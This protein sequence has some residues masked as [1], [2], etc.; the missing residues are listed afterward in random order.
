[1]P[2]GAEPRAAARP[3]FRLSSIASTKHLVRRGLEPAA[4]QEA[5]LRVARAFIADLQHPSDPEAAAVL[6]QIDGALEGN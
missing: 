1:M 3:P 6:A 2:D 5:A 4:R